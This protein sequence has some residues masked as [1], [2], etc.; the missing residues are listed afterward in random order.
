ML[1]SFSLWI[2]S[3]GYVALATVCLGEEDVPG[4]DVDRLVFRICFV[5]LSF[6]LSWLSICC[7]CIMTFLVFKLLLHGFTLLV[8]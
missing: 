6:A 4:V 5:L 3:R 2:A 7:C 1:V 8:V